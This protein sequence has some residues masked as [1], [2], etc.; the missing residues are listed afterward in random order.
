VNVN[1]TNR[2]MVKLNG[3]E[4]KFS[5]DFVV[6]PYS[7]SVKG[8]FTPVMVNA[9]LMKNPDKL[10]AILQETAGPKVVLMIRRI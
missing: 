1:V 8:M 5:K 4:L 10:L 7:A 2:L 6:T 3:Q 9:S